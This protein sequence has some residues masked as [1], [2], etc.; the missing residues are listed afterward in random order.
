MEFPEHDNYSTY[1]IKVMQSAEDIAAA[2]ETNTV[3]SIDG[4][5][6]NIGDEGAELIAVALERNT[7]VTYINLAGNLIGDAG[8]ERILD[9]LETNITVTD[10]DL[11]CNGIEQG[12]LE[13]IDDCLAKNA[14]GLRVVTVWE[15][16]VVG[17]CRVIK[18]TTPGG[19]EIAT[20][21]LPHESSVLFLE[22][23]I[24]RRLNFRGHL[25]LI[26]PDGTLL[27][28]DQEIVD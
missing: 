19:E 12:T 18:C 9:A 15:E 6:L 14:A 20:V 22:G 2:L 21:E 5:G 16:E 26:R 8:A 10:I 3:T 4:A 17:E 24:E 23:L 25:R 1:C 28:W 13:A 7:T 27:T 11:G